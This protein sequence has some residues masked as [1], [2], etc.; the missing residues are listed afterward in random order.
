MST[1]TFVNA[2]IGL[3]REHKKLE[4]R[5]AKHPNSSWAM[6][7]KPLGLEVT[8]DMV[9][10]GYFDPKSSAVFGDAIEEILR[11]CDVKRKPK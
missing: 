10:T 1:Q 9:S 5:V 6:R 8:E 3:M 7:F 11:S 4:R 2:L